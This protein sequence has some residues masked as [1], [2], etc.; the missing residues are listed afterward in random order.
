MMKF[1]VAK[2]CAAWLLISL[3]SSGA[4]AEPARVVASIKPVH[5]LVS[6]VMRGIG[7]PILLIDGAST[8]HGFSLRPSQARH[9]S[10]ADVVFWIGPAM[11]SGLVRPLRSLGRNALLVSLLEAKGVSRLSFRAGQSLRDNGH[12]RE[13]STPNDES[14]GPEHQDGHADRDD[15]SSH[16]EH[17]HLAL[18]GHAWLDPRNAIAMTEAI[19]HHLAES[20]PSKA[21]QIMANAEA[22]A[23]RL[24][25]LDSELEL[26]FSRG[27]KPPYLVFHD[28]YQYFEVRYGLHSLGAI[29]IDPGRRPGAQRL[30]EVRNK[31]KSSGATCV[32]AEPQFESK[33]V[34]TV[35]EGSD[36]RKYLLDPLGTDIAK[37]P[38]LY[39]TLIRNLADVMSECFDGGR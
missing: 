17:D 37:G 36:A 26:R 3:V 25:A 7:E 5:S 18:D 38:T 29:A 24:M 16:G 11:E 19:A 39:F 30:R 10:S 23:V 15:E 21:E 22:Q 32:F 8:P 6:A 14:R 12:D 27:P 34:D 13:G 31:I 20:Y 4:G 9:L 35:I 1:V 28:A 33:L 2:I